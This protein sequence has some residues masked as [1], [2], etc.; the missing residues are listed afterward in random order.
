MKYDILNPFKDYLE[1][2][3]CKNTARKYYSSVKNALKDLDFNSA[4]E[5]DKNYLLKKLQTTRTKNK[6][7]ALKN[8]LKNLQEFDSRLQLPEEKVMSDLAGHKRN[9]VKS[10]NRRVDVDTISKKVNAGRNPKLKYACRLAMISGLRVAELA[11]LEPADITFNPDQTMQ[12]NV[13]NGKGGISRVSDCLQDTY[14]YNRL[15]DYVQN[16]P[17]GQKLFYDESTMRR[18]AWEHEM[19]MHDFRRIFANLLKNELKAEGFS[20]EEIEE[21]VQSRLGH[22]R[23]SNTKRYLYG[24]KVVIKYKFSKAKEAGES[25]V[26][27]DDIALDSTESGIYYN[28][29]SD[30]DSG[31]ISPEEESILT[32][33]TSHN[34]K[35]INKALYAGDDMELFDEQIKVMEE[36]IDRK[37]IPE[38]VLLYRGIN[39][40]NILFGSDSGL[41]LDELNNKYQNTAFIHKSFVST[42]MNRDNAAMFTDNPDN[43]VLLELKVPAGSKGI[44]V[45]SIS[46]YT[47]EQEVI[48]QRGSVLRIEN[49][50]V[51]EGLTIAH[52]KLEYQFN[53]RV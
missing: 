33:Y 10:K 24:R 18:Y 22:A 36:C 48:L 31:D 1:S 32:S 7:S 53:R 28:F 29:L 35:F 44:Y 49:I 16:T 15:Y 26:N 43:G 23:L 5:I 17:P 39:D 47:T 50:T 38:N 12:I 2:K 46:K 34:Y 11:D 6:Y 9:W 19:E 41:S 51:E 3:Y 40:K 14:L 13:R 20:K 52:V 45:S 8:G 4:E 27:P 37:I 30:L 25:S 42:S 21:K